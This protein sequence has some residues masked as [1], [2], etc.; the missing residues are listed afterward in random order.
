MRHKAATEFT[1]PGVDIKDGE[2]NDLDA[3][4]LVVSG[5]V[6]ANVLGLHTL[7]Y[8]YTSADGKSAKEITRNVIVEDNQEPDL[9]LVGDEVVR[10]QV[11]AEYIDSGVSA[12]DDLDGAITVHYDSEIPTDGLVLHLD[13]EVLHS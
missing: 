10:I 8:N 11:G 1:D 13:A 9:T 6:D 5:T 7:T 4:P 2:G 3:G 12:L